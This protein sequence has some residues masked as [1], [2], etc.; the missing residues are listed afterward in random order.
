MNLDIL[1]TGT[2]DNYAEGMKGGNILNYA[3]V[4][5]LLKD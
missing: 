2:I 3:V 4:D 1:I 5:D